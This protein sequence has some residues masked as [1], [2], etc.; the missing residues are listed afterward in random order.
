MKKSFI[1]Q[2]DLIIF[3][4]DGT[5]YDEKMYLFNCYK[6]I[7]EKL[8]P[9]HKREAE[10]YLC[11]TFIKEGRENLFNKLFVKFGCIENISACLNIMRTSRMPKSIP[12]YAPMLDFIKQANASCIVTNGNVMQQRNKIKYLD[13]QGLSMDVFYANTIEPKPSAAIFFQEIQPKYKPKSILM[14]GDTNIDNQ[15]ADNIGAEFLYVDRVLEK[16]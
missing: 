6:N 8:V 7:A 9:K 11:E 5:L 1:Q 2:F 13:W 16:L 12:L 3:D 10:I 4:L 15:F 14:V